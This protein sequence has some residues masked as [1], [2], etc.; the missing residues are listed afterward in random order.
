VLVINLLAD[1]TIDERI[2]RS[3]EVKQDLSDYILGLVA[4]GQPYLSRAA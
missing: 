3:H 2:T 4:S 1:R